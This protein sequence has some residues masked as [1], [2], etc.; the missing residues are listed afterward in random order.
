MLFFLQEKGT[1][2]EENGMKEENSNIK[3]HHPLQ[4]YCKQCGHG[5]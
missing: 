5:L 4:I 3:I 2:R 1:F